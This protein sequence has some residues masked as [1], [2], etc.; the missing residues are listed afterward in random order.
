ML[1][2]VDRANTYEDRK[3]LDLF[4]LAKSQET[5]ET[6]KNS[7]GFPRELEVSPEMAKKFEEAKARRE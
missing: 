3:D 4:E 6:I 7:K 2:L 5:L 1:G